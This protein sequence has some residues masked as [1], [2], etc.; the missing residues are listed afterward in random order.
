MNTSLSYCIG[1]TTGLAVLKAQAKILEDS[2]LVAEVIVNLITAIRWGI[3]QSQVN[4]DATF[5]DELAAVQKA[6]PYTKISGLLPPA[7]EPTKPV[8]G[9]PGTVRELRKLCAHYGIPRASRLSKSAAI[10]ALSGLGI[11]V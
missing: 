7:A 9:I 11:A 2:A 10:A 4:T 5:Q 3:D 8:T 1:Y 6:L